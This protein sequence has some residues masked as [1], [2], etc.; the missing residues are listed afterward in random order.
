METKPMR[1]LEGLHPEDGLRTWRCDEIYGATVYRKPR[2]DDADGEMVPPK[3]RRSWPFRFMRPG[4]VA[5]FRDPDEFVDARNAAMGV[6]RGRGEGW[7]FKC[8][9]HYEIVKDRHGRR[10]KVTWLEIEREE[11][12]DLTVG[13]RAMLT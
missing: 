1:G 5:I 12:I 4:D 9:T 8:K 6:Q 3:P 13:R 10:R 11:V 2:D 7:Y